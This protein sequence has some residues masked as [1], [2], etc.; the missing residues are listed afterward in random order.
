MST[1][2]TGGWFIMLGIA[3]AVCLAAEKY[4]VAHDVD[5]AH[6]RTHQF[7]FNY[8]DEHVY[9]VHGDTHTKELAA[10]N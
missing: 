10:L 5:G 9:T 4:A 6:N 7:H 2:S 1:I 8:N 3:I